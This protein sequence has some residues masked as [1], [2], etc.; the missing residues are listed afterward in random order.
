MKRHSAAGFVGRVGGLAVALGVGAVVSLGAPTA[1][2]DETTVDGTS[3]SSAPA[4][5]EQ[6]PADSPAKD[7]AERTDTPKDDSGT[8]VGEDNPASTQSDEPSAGAEESAP[9]PVAAQSPDGNDRKGA[10]HRAPLKA[11]APSEDPA[12]VKTAPAGSEPGGRLPDV[13]AGRAVSAHPEVEVAAVHVAPQPSPTASVVVAPVATPDTVVDPA[14]PAITSMVVA[15]KAASTLQGAQGSLDDD[16]GSLA[17]PMVMVMAA[18]ARREVGATDTGDA[19]TAT[20]QTTAQPYAATLAA[21]APTN[22]APVITAAT[23]NA[24]GFFFGWVGGKVTATDAEKDW[25]TYAATTTTKGTVS[26]NAFTG[27]FTYAPTAAARHAAAADAATDADKHDVVTAT[28]TDGK[29]GV[30]SQPVTVSIRPANNAPTVGFFGLFGV[31]V[32]SPN[33]STGVVTGKVMAIDADKDT[34]KYSAANTAKGTVVVDA[35]GGFTYTPTTAARLAA[36]ATGAPWS[37]LSDTFA[38]T[39]NDGHG[40]STIQAVNVPIAPLVKPT[41]VVDRGTAQLPSGDHVL[42]GNGAR[43]LIVN[44]AASG[45][46]ESPAVDVS[47]V[48]TADGTRVGATVTLAGYEKSTP[49]LTADGTRAVVTTYTSTGAGDTTGIAVID[50]TSGAQIGTTLTL[51][52]YVSGVFSFGSN[53]LIVGPNSDGSETQFAVFD[54]KTSTQVG[55]TRTL[56]GAWGSP[57]F[58]ADYTRA[59]FATYTD[60]AVLDTATLTQVGSTI[61][62]PGVSN[63]RL[64][65]AD[66][67]RFLVL[68]AV[69]DTVAN[70]SSTVVTIVDTATGNQVAAPLT[71]VGASVTPVLTADS[72]R[73]VITTGETHDGGYSL[74]NAQVTVVDLNSAAQVG[75]TVTI[76]GDPNYPATLLSSDGTGALIST[77]TG[78][79]AIIDTKTGSQIGGTFTISGRPDSFEFVNA[80]HT[81][82]VIGARLDGSSP[83]DRTF[84][85]TVIDTT[86][87]AQIGSGVTV[88]GD[89]YGTVRLSADGT[90]ALIVVP[91][92]PPITDLWSL[93]TAQTYTSAA[94]IDTTTGRQTGSTLRLTGAP[95]GPAPYYIRLLSPGNTRFLVIT[96]RWNQ[97]AYSGSVLISV[98]DGTTGVQSGSTVTIPGKL[99]DD[100]VFNADGT[101]FVLLHSVPQRFGTAPVLISTVWI[102]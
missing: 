10:K 46:A 4:A 48:R 66:T 20:G 85:A 19:N 12:P 29:G 34:L 87:G 41:G 80:A 52:R 62:L 14:A 67:K 88:P 42:V 26:V 94:V 15:S 25:L 32:D 45:T 55:P 64:M 18:A 33:A 83:F 91:D 90:H 56:S 23:A 98:I 92:I 101:Q 30:A 51:D 54:T 72:S 50:T 24:P 71:L 17:T 21:A 79:A 5:D 2:A 31:R 49:V 61:T 47:L 76:P 63:W 58:N 59:V 86:T 36:G 74:I 38:V 37:A 102:V 100:P 77:A 97:L 65:S 84:R 96:N 40:G 75:T 22:Q 39:I 93:L 69:N 27:D 44:Y 1:W 13:V 89:D 35:S 9:E 8:D 7:P 73:A 6:G 95:T 78:S 99:T 43:A 68:S 82:A 81:R 53:A 11:A 28:V 60:V 16:L 3:G 70:S 57:I